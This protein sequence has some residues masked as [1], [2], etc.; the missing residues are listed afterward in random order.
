MF[1]AGPLQRSAARWS[2]VAFLV[3][4]ALL[5]RTT[6]A[7]PESFSNVRFT[8]SPSAMHV[9]LILPVRDLSRWFPPG[10]YKNYTADVVRELSTQVGDLL[11]VGWDGEIAKPTHTNVHAGQVGFI[12]VEED[13]VTPA[14]AGSL[15]VRSALLENLPNDHQE[16]ALVEDARGGPSTERILAEETLTAQQDDFAVDL[17]EVAVPVKTAPS[18]TKTL[19]SG[20]MTNPVVVR[21]TRRTGIIAIIALAT[22]L[23]AIGLARLARGRTLST[24]SI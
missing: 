18:A 14:K 8:L 19:A 22:A 12:I 21:P 3:A 9:T 11:V 5:S 6:L 10:R 4:T 16:L 2:V 7:H 13:F 1:P 15:A 17:P 23:A 24:R 20:G